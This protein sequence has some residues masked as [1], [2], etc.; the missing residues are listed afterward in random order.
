MD[1]SHQP[2]TVR[3]NPK[4]SVLAVLALGGAIYAIANYL[5]FKNGLFSEDLFYL[6]AFLALPI[7]IFFLFSKSVE[8]SF[9]KIRVVW[10]YGLI[11][12]EYLLG[13]VDI[14]KQTDLLCWFTIEGKTIEINRD[15]DGFDVGVTFIQELA[16]NRNPT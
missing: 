5:P 7:G 4:R 12:Q 8:F 9:H 14:S 1:N 10:G 11:C 2:V 16:K 13:S 15:M 6:L 3:Y